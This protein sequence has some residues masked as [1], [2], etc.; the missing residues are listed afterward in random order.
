MKQG[1]EN[2]YNSKYVLDHNLASVSLTNK[3]LLKYSGLGK[4][5][6]SYRHSGVSMNVCVNLSLLWDDRG[7]DIIISIKET[8]H[9][10]FYKKVSP[11]QHL[12]LPLFP[13]SCCF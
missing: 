2:P 3:H 12:L 11:I 7:I 13:V 1:L 10:H 6:V 5:I 4:V 8:K 9:Y